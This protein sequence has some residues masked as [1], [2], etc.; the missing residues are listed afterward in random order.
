MGGY[1]SRLKKNN[2]WAACYMNPSLYHELKKK[3]KKNFYCSIEHY[4]YKIKNKSFLVIRVYYHLPIF[5]LM[6]LWY[7]QA[8]KFL[9][10][11]GTITVEG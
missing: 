10:Y 9:T 7:N 2:W 8:L 6:L 3:K 5:H 11:R 1:C 4:Y